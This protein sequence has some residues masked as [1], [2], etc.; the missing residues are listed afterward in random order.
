MSE[1]RL[2]FIAG[3][4]ASGKSAAALAF[5]EKIDAE[6]INADASQIYR[7]LN[8][9]TARPSDEDLA[10]APHHLYGVLDPETRC[11]A[12]RWSVMAADLIS[13]LHKSERPI[14]V[15]GGT[16][17]YFR[18]L[19]EGLSPIPETPPEIRQRAQARRDEV[20]SAAFYEEVVAR[21]PDMAHLPEG[22]RQRLMRAW[23]VLEATGKP[24]SYFQSLPKTP[25]ISGP[26]ERVVIAPPRETLYQRC[27]ARAVAMVEGGALEEVEK[28]LALNLDPDLPIMKSLGVREL[29]AHLKGECDLDEAVAMLQQN[30]RRFAK[31]QMTWVRGQMSDWKTHERAEDAVNALRSV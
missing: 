30:T 11:S 21:D 1:Q 24:L 10:R 26:V 9:L 12:G 31:R 18:A 16:G 7:D 15:V 25:L 29:G 27:D 8:I 19:E 20:G 23:E 2:F 13:D 4:T 5:A 22:D 3:P 28:L 14:I 17:L 6:I